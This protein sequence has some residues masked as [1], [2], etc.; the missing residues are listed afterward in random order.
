MEK[1]NMVSTGKLLN[2]IKEEK[3]EKGLFLQGK[4]YTCPDISIYLCNLLAERNLEVK[5]VVKRLNIER[6]YGYQ[7]FNGTRK[8]TRN[9]LIRLAVLLEL[10]LEETNRLLKIGRKEVLYPRRR[11]DAAVIFAL[12]KKMSPEEL[13]EI[14]EELL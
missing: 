3:P 6:S 2:Q 10:P 7:M 8:P 12:E 13:Q 5:D 4:E 11:E 9:L 1:E 14:Q